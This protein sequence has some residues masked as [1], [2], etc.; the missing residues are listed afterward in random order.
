MNAKSM[1]FAAAVLVLGGCAGSPA[2][3]FQSGTAMAPP[4]D[5]SVLVLP[6]DIVVSQ[7]SVGG[8]NE[9]RADWTEAATESLNGALDEFFFN[10]GVMPVRYA[11]DAIEDEDLDIIRQANINLDAIQLA[12]QG[13]AMP[14]MREYALTPELTRSLEEYGADYAVFV[15]LRARQASAGR[16]AARIL[17]NPISIESIPDAYRVALFDLRDG[18]VVW[19]NM[20]PAA[21]RGLGNPGEADTGR[22]L[23]SFETLF[24][25]FPL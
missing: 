10:R 2:T 7:V 9:P 25:G 21:Y 18:Q 22:W 5:A 13:D 1:M 6:A 24:R 3:V 8:N 17:R 15:M 20:D 12:Q 14:G 4:L 11:S 23:R 19:A 16:T